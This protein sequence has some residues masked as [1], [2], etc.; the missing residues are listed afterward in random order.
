ME[1]N[2]QKYFEWVC[3][4]YQKVCQLSKVWG[5]PQFT[6][7]T[8][9]EITTPYVVISSYFQFWNSGAFVHMYIVHYIYLVCLVLLLDG[10]REWM[11]IFRTT[12]NFF[13]SCSLS[14]AMMCYLFDLW[15]TWLFCR[16]TIG[17][18]ACCLPWF[19]VFTQ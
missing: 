9:F 17:V 10:P 3:Y 4:F 7:L 13:N 19:S 8:I 1:V 2:R 15:F 16:H 5:A 11:Y 14:P 6:G 18:V 12:F